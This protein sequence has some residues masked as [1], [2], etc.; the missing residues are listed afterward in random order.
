MSEHAIELPELPE[1]EEERTRELDEVTDITHEVITSDETARLETESS[2]YAQESAVLDRQIESQ[3]RVQ[4]LE[5][6]SSAS[7]PPPARRALRRGNVVRSSAARRRLTPFTMYEPQY[8]ARA[9]VAS[10][11][12]LELAKPSSSR[13]SSWEQEVRNIEQHVDIFG[14]SLDEFFADEFTRAGQVTD[15]DNDAM[16]LSSLTKQGWT[17]DEVRNALQALAASA[18]D[19]AKPADFVAAI[20]A[21]ERLLKDLTAMSG[22]LAYDTSKVPM[23]GAKD[24]FGVITTVAIG[25]RRKLDTLAAGRGIR[26]WTPEQRCYDLASRLRDLEGGPHDGVLSFADKTGS[27]N[28]ADAVTKART[29]VANLDITPDEQQALRT[30]LKRLGPDLDARVDALMLVIGSSDPASIDNM[31][32]LG[33]EFTRLVRSVQFQLEQ[34]GLPGIGARAI[35]QDLQNVLANLIGY[36]ATHAFA[37]SGFPELNG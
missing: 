25:V 37:R 26:P 21:G 33:W 27:T 11:N 6:G 24:Y 23:T 4:A 2:D 20:E 5:T 3:E 32:A 18:A 1:S 29:A 34:L 28:W 14:A 16:I 13:S 19:P 15:P 9:Q 7:A 17:A 35:L 12:L 36:L 10:E 31:T 22:A 8:V 30:A